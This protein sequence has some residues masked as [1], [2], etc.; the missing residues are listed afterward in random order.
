MT[1]A[2]VA[3]PQDAKLVP[4]ESWFAAPATPPAAP[5]AAPPAE[6]GA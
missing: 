5:A 1:P 2:Y 3:D 6:A 4:K